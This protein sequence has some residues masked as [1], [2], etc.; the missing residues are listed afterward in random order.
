MNNSQG[1]QRQ[2]THHLPHAGRWMRAGRIQQEDETTG[3]T[4]RE[5]DSWHH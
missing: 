2:R 5:S 4:G 1:K 3:E